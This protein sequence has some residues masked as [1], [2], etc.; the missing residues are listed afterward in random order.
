MHSTAFDRPMEGVK[1]VTVEELNKSNTLSFLFE[2]KNK[3]SFWYATHNNFSPFN[4]LEFD[5][6]LLIFLVLFPFTYL[7]F[8]QSFLF[9][10]IG[11]FYSYLFRS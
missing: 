6:L 10:A 2:E 7:G 11:L 4:D 5:I 9:G 8:H 1:T 3:E